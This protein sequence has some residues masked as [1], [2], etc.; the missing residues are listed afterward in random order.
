MNQTYLISLFKKNE[1]DLD[2][3]YSDDFKSMSDE[4]I[5]IAL[6]DCIKYLSIELMSLTQS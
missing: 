3:V 1:F 4:D 6:E 2:I 5:A